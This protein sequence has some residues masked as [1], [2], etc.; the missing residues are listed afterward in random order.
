MSRFRQQNVFS[1]QPLVYP[2]VQHIRDEIQIIYCH[3]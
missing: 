3:L 2:E 1:S